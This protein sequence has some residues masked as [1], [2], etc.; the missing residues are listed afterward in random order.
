MQKMAVHCFAQWKKVE[1]LINNAGVAFSG[2]VGDTPLKD[3][4]WIVGINSWG[5]IYGCHY[6]IPR[7]KERKYC[8]YSVGRQ[9]YLS[10]G[11][12]KT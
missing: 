10:A 9:I 6:F 1:L 12:G 3:W 7:M 4:E 11:N 8:Q 2:F 5:T